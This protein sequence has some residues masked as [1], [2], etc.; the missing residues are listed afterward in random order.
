[1]KTVKIYVNPKSESTKV[2]FA[3]IAKHI[4]EINRNINIRRVLVTDKNKKAVISLGITALPTLVYNGKLYPGANKI[5]SMLKPPSAHKDNYGQFNSPEE[6][7]EKYMNKAIQPNN[8]H[9]DDDEDDRQ[10][11]RDAQLRQRMT[12]FSKRREGMIGGKNNPNTVSGKNKNRKSKTPSFNN[13]ED[14]INAYDQGD[15]T[16]TEQYNMEDD[17]DLIWENE[18]NEMADAMGRKPPSKMRR[19]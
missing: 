4:D 19:H 16:P 18:L 12:D 9:E 6:M 15:E 5:M 14:F 3:F 8:E 17:G 13:D 11:Q 10:N 1:M 2:L 7:L